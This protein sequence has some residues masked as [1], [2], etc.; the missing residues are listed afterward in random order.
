MSVGQRAGEG[1]MI[2]IGS[3]N[4]RNVEQTDH[5]PPKATRKK[6]T[7]MPRLFSSLPDHRWVRMLM[8]PSAAASARR[9]VAERKVSVRHGRA[10]LSG[11]CPNVGSAEGDLAIGRDAATATLAAWSGSAPALRVG[12]NWP[13]RRDRRSSPA[14]IF[15]GPWHDN[16]DPSTGGGASSVRRDIGRCRHRG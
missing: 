7:R 14:P 3:R 2:T 11:A 12:W 6:V 8:A 4:A 16:A 9:Q 5:A 13:P 10:R 1:D 15:T